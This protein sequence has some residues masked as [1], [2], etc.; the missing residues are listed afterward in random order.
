M[1]HRDEIDVWEDLAQDN[2]PAHNSLPH[3]RTPEEYV[4]PPLRDLLDFETRTFRTSGKKERAVRETF[5]L[6]YS[7]YHQLLNAAINDP[8]A[9]ALEPA[10]VYRLREHR[11]TRVTNR[12]TYD[13]RKFAK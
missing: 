1:R 9:L 8:E 12:R 10:L 2:P 4:K 5:G 3:A 13:F 11:T 6:S 7:R